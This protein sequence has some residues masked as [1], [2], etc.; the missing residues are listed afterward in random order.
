MGSTPVVRPPHQTSNPLGMRASRMTREIVA[1]NR[2]G[3]GAPI[4][5]NE[6]LDSQDQRFGG[7][8]TPRETPVVV[9]EQ[10]EGARRI[11]RCE[12]SRF[13]EQRHLFREL[14]LDA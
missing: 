14:R 2:L 5:S 7:E 1:R 3:P 12:S 11:A 10:R 9:I 8:I 4:A 6:R 13:V